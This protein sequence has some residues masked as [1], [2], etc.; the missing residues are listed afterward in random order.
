MDRRDPETVAQLTRFARLSS[1]GRTGGH[2][3]IEEPKQPRHDFFSANSSFSMQSAFSPEPKA[4]TA[5]EGLYKKCRRFVINAVTTYRHDI[6]QSCEEGHTGGYL[7]F[8][9]VNIVRFCK[10]IMYVRESMLKGKSLATIRKTHSHAMQYLLSAVCKHPGSRANRGL[11]EHYAEQFKGKLL[12]YAHDTTP[13]KAWEAFKEFLKRCGVKAG[14]PEQ[15][16]RSFI[17]NSIWCVSVPPSERDAAV[18]PAKIEPDFRP[19]VK[20]QPSEEFNLEFHHHNFCEVIRIPPRHHPAA[21]CLIPA[22]DPMTAAILDPSMWA[23]SCDRGCEVCMC[24][25]MMDLLEREVWLMAPPM[26]APP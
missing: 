8:E 24:G 26:M 9:M 7:I 22:S 12:T 16:N 6:V 15:S 1:P 20:Y 10:E 2:G 5:S 4:E 25:S 11:S 18:I 14:R 17:S 3:C 19:E 23:Y 21:S 13:R